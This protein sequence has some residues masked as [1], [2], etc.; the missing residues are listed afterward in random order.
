VFLSERV[1]FPI[2][3]SDVIGQNRQGRK[4][5]KLEPRK[6]CATVTEFCPESTLRTDQETSL[7]ARIRG[8]HKAN[9]A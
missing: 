5:Q 9:P 1:Y 8:L 7:A 6:N 4:S 3:S 2:S